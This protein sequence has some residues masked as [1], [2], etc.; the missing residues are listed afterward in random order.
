MEKEEAER[1]ELQRM[2]RGD[3][4]KDMKKDKKKDGSQMTPSS[5]VSILKIL[6]V[7]H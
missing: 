6:I 3:L 5:G 7:L 2:L 4:G 1:M